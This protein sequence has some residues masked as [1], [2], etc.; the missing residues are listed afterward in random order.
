[1]DTISHVTVAVRA[2]DEIAVYGTFDTRDDAA[3]TAEWLIG[4]GRLARAIGL[5]RPDIDPT[6]SRAIVDVTGEVIELPHPV[7]HTLDH[8]TPAASLEDEAVVSLLVQPPARALA[9]F[10]GPFPT[11]A[12]ARNWI[13]TATTHAS[14]GTNRSA[15]HIH[16]LQHTDGVLTPRV[17]PCPNPSRGNRRDARTAGRANATR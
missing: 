17:P 12:H 3:I 9:L 7:A 11:A 4:R 1:M 5:H 6:T 15:M 14:E 2:T 13:H 8:T 10:I 16:P